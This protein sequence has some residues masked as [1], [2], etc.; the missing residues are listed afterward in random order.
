MQQTRR[1]LKNLMLMTTRMKTSF[2]LSSL[3]SYKLMTA[4]T[5]MMIMFHEYGHVS[6]GI[7]GMTT[8]R[9]LCKRNV[10]QNQSFWCCLFTQQPSLWRRIC[11][12]CSDMCKRNLVSKTGDCTSDLTVNGGES[13]WGCWLQRLRIM[14]VEFASCI[15]WWSITK[16][17]RI[18]TMRR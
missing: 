11:Y 10:Q 14:R 7:F 18:S 9:C 13:V 17:W 12:R 15:I 16:S 8:T 5:M 2:M 6:K 4:R 3:W 1:L